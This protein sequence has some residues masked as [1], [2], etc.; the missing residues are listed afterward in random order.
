MEIG[1]SIQSIGLVRVARSGAQSYEEAAVVGL[2]EASAGGGDSSGA[3]GVEGGRG[4]GRGMGPC[5]L[6][7]GEGGGRGR[8]AAGISTALLS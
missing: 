4:E 1:L 3:Q 2:G 5:G 8:A 7:Q 6:S